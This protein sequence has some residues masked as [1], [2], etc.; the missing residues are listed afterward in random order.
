MDTITNDASWAIGTIYF[1]SIIVSKFLEKVNLDAYKLASAD[2][3]NTPLQ[4]K[5]AKTNK[6]IFLSTGGGNYNDIKRAYQTIT[7]KSKFIKYILT[8]V[9]L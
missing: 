5:I 4:I 9:F 8:Y 1:F 6:P 3:I 7:K 2:L